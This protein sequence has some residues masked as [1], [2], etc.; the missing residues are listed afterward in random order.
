M[1]VS[2]Q[3][4]DLEVLPAKG[5]RAWDRL[6]H[7]IEHRISTHYISASPIP[8]SNVEHNQLRLHCYHKL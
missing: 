8:P 3:A 7:A 1:R 2:V 6:G 5:N 4:C